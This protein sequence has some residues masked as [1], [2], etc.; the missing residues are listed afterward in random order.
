MRRLALVGASALALVTVACSGGGSSNPPPPPATGAFSNA[1]LQGTYAFSMSGTDAS[2]QVGAF[3]ARAG[4][5]TADGKGNISAALED[6]S[7][8]GSVQTV[9]FNGGT[10]SIQ[11]DGK[12]TLTLNTVG[13][14]GLQFT[15]ALNSSSKGVMIQTDLNATSSGSFLLQSPNSFSLSG[16]SGS[17]VF[18]VSGADF[19]GAP[20][21][22]V[23]QMTTNGGG[24]I[25]GG[26]Y[27]SNDGGSNPPLITA[28]TFGA[29]GTYTLDPSNG[30]TFGRGTMTFASRTFAFYI[31]DG[32]R[33]RLIETDGQLST[34]G[35][36]LQ[37]TGAPMQAA[38]GSFAF[39]IGGSS[40]LGTAGPIGRGARF[41][42][43]ASGAATKIQLDDNNNGHLTSIGS[44]TTISN[45]KFT[46]DAANPGTGRGTLTFTASAS[47]NAGTFTFVF[48]LASATQG[49]I[50]DT[51]NGVVGDGTLLAQTGTFSAANLA[52]NY[53]FNLSGINLSLGFEEDFAGQYGLSS[54]GGI[55][56]AVDFVELA[57]PSKRNPAF[58]DIPLSG[59]LTISGDGSGANNYTLTTGN[60]PSTTLNYHAYIG[61]ANTILLVGVDTNRVSAGNASLQP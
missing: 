38:A 37:Q 23:G 13:G 40:V 19:N 20:I 47:P 18:D 32:T 29:G 55:A 51:S 34:L 21:S 30:A 4:S 54:S 16:I 45:A 44:S 35:D 15:I 26:V 53:V 9:T 10:Y 11:G 48:Y 25:T 6:V 60:S 31:V 22:V 14:T 50:Q 28:Q 42:T 33:I 52:G 24:A 17:Y 46:I 57:S 12:G 8:A 7:D 49:F 27:D 43:D 39:L 3:I 2:A 59:M 58:L 41:T 36:A 61:G 1:N 56:G 5:F